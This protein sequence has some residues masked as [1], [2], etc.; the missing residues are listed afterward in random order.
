M[1]KSEH[2]AQGTGLVPGWSEAQPKIVN[3][4]IDTKSSNYYI[5]NNWLNSIHSYPDAKQVRLKM[6]TAKFWGSQDPK[7]LYQNLR[8]YYNTLH[9]WGLCLSSL[10]D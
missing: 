3:S 5:I 9:F 7:L 10:E 2:K 4:S 8:I 6:F 1:H